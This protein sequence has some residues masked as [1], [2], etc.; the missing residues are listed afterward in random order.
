[1]VPGEIVYFDLINGPKGYFAN[2]IVSKH[3]L[4]SK[5]RHSDKIYIHY[6]YTYKKMMDK[7]LDEEIEDDTSSDVVNGGG[8]SDINDS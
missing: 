4:N 3:R 1:M 6:Y 7:I 8:S 5:V 2:N